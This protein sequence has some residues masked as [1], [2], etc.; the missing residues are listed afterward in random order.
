MATSQPFLVTMQP[1]PELPQPRRRSL[2]VWLVF[3]MLLAIAVLAIVGEI[4][5]H[6]ANPI[7][8]GRVIETLSARFDSKVELDSLS[9]SL[10][11]GLE[12]SGEGLR[13]FA[14]DDVVAAGATRPIIAV[15]QFSFHASLRGLFIK[16]TRVGTVYVSGLEIH[17]PPRQMRDASG[18]SAH[19]YGG[20]IKI[21]VDHFLCVHSDL[22]IDSGNPAKE[23]KRFALDRIELWEIGPDAPWRYDATLVNA[24]PRG[25]IHATGTFGPWVNESAGDSSVAGHY[26]FDHADLNPI[27]GIGGTLSSV[28]DFHGQL[29]RIAVAG[30][31]QTPD[32]SLDTASHPMPLNTSFGAI[33]DGTTGDTYLN[34]V[35]AVLNHTRIDCTGSVVNIRGKGH[36]IDLDVDIPEANTANQQR[37][38]DL[39]ELAVKTHPVYLT[40]QIMARAK[41]HIR[42]GPESVTQ[43]L[44]VKGAFTLRNIHFTN[45][46]VQDKVDDL[47]L[48][49][50]GRPAEAKAGAPDQLS[51]MTGTFALDR[52]RIHFDKLEYTLPGAHVQLTGLYSLDGEQFDF[53][54]TVRTEAKVSQMVSSW[55]KQLLL[56]PVDPFFRK[57][58][59]GTEVPIKISGTH[60]EPKFGLDFGH[61]DKQPH[62][63]INH[64]Y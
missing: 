53:H 16:P 12:V 44:S 14:P 19:R 4:L 18:V 41:L 35:Q 51:Q 15:K 49:A 58:G 1:P 36:V 50:Q 45:P 23:P 2:L 54:G 13:I 27:K 64:Q 26:T 17:I 39:L 47:S 11:K 40:A 7:L 63:T 48:R 10:I 37:L 42:P 22:V 60:N 3:A 25:N 59:A 46:K 5:I 31:T 38:Q 52:G 8:K 20:K 56:K 24:I 30:T 55:W 57:N 33:V 9:V 6:R 28:G 32:F 61:K 29:N 43:K 34:P 62:P 21:A